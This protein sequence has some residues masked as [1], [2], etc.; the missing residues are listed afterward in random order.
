MVQRKTSP[1]KRPDFKCLRG[2]PSINVTKGCA[3]GCIYCYARGFP[4]APPEGE[5]HLYGNLPDMMEEELSRM[6]RIPLWV[7][8]STASDPFQPF[9]EVL[10]VTYRGMKL[11][12]TSGIGVT[13]L[14]KGIIPDDFLKLFERYPGLVR[15][16]IGVVSIREDYW[17]VF[18][19]GTPHPLERLHSVKRLRGSGVEV[20]VRVD[21]VV[22]VVAD[23]QEDLEVL[24]SS[25]KD[26]G[27]KEIALSCLVMRPS[28]EEFLREKL[29]EALCKRILGYYRRQV[30]QRVI[31][32][33]RTKLLPL[34]YRKLLYKRVFE[35]AKN[36]GL[37]VKICGCK[38]PDL[39]WQNC[40]PWVKRGETTYQD[41]QPRLFGTG[42]PPENA[43]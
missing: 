33:A 24:F 13:F 16:R 31:T 8:F 1:F 10:E 18:E 5:I 12:L 14:T 3:H 9:D 30:Y 40:S 20:S 28:I 36:K 39:P 19:P 32:S 35:I 17:M 4:E 29:P 27:V 6:K 15:A 41:R 34:S 42:S 11:L 26:S 25:I 23:E 22:P 2:I 37:R 21:P 43:D 7:S 38:N